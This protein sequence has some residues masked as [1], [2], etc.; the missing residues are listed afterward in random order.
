MLLS[1]FLVWQLTWCLF[2]LLVGR[3]INDALLAAFYL[4][5][6]CR[7]DVEGCKNATF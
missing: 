3:G 5:P 1:F 7:A 2:C 6:I 4:A